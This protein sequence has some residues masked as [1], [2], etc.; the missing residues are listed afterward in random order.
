[1]KTFV[2]YCEQEWKRE[3]LMIETVPSSVKQALNLSVLTASPHT[4]THT[5]THSLSL[6]GCCSRISFPGWWRNLEIRVPH[7][8]TVPMYWSWEWAS[9][10]VHVWTRWR[11]RICHITSL[12]IN[13][14]TWTSNQ[15]E[16]DEVT[17]VDK[18]AWGHLTSITSITQP[19]TVRPECFMHRNRVIHL[20]LIF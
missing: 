16:K 8:E 17:S 9:C 2:C 6:E 15:E 12:S 13:I 19:F 14:C 10:S 3:R 4:H 18:H 11:G 1:M 5:H 7:R 20:L